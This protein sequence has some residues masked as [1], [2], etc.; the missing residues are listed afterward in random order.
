MAPKLSSFL[1]MILDRGETTSAASVALAFLDPMGSK[2]T[3]AFIVKLHDLPD[4]VVAGREIAQ[5][6]VRIEHAP[7]LLVKMLTARVVLRS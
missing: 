2:R 4:E 7:K 1:A 6:C 3:A 5:A